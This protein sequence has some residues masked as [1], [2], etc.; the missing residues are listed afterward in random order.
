MIRKVVDGF[1]KR[2]TMERFLLRLP[3]ANVVMVA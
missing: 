2:L 1:R 3:N